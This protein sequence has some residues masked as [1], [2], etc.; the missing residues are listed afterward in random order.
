MIFKYRNIKNFLD[1]ILAFILVIILSPIYLII[2]LIIFINMGQPIIFS[3]RRPGYKNKIFKIY[4]FRTMR[5]I[6]NSEGYLLPD[7]ERI[8]KIGNFL[9]SN[10]LDELPQLFN[11]VIGN[12]SFIG[13]RPLLEEYLPLY[14]KEQSTR[15]NV[16]PGLTCLSQINGRNSINWEKKFYF[17]I[18]YVNNYSF[19]MDLKILLIT[20]WK[21]LK[22]EGINSS[23]SNPMDIFRGN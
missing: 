23:K 9:R 22:K 13:P 6:Y 16:K 21:V 7:S 1:R 4:K 8:T 18:L 17:D 2:G 11:I 19:L 14:N 3:Q 12:M 20:F 15:H 5:I 10:S